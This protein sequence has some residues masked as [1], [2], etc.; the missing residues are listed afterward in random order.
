MGVERYYLHVQAKDAA[1]NESAVETGYFFIDENLPAP[2]SA[3]SPPLT[4]GVST[5]KYIPPAQASH[6]DLESIL[7]FGSSQMNSYVQTTCPEGWELKV[8]EEFASDPHPQRTF[9]QKL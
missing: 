4:E 6:E 3:S 5:E 8:P 9:C 1:G 7:T 2:L